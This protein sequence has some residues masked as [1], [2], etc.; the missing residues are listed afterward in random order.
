MESKDWFVYD[1]VMYI[2]LFI[3]RL[4]GIMYDEQIENDPTYLVL[5]LLIILQTMSNITIFVMQSLTVYPCLDM[6]I[7]VSLNPF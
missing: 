1:L 3:P 2:V 4:T 5:D 6:Y 7:S